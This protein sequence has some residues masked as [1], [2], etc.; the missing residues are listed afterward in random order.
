M[1][2][3]S[4]LFAPFYLSATLTAL[5]GCATQA[6]PEHAN[7]A[8]MDKKMA[9]T[10][11]KSEVETACVG[12]QLE[13]AKTV[14]AVFDS[15]GML[16]IGYV[17]DKYLYLQSSADRGQTFSPAVKVNQ[18]QEGIAARDESRPKIKFDA[19]DNLY[20]TWTSDI[21]N[22]KERHNGNVRFSRSTDGGKTFSVPVTVNDENPEVAGH[23]FD[24][25]AIGKNGEIFIA[26]LDARDKVA[27]K[28]S[29]TEHLGSSVY[30]AWSDDGGK[31]FQ[32]NKLAAAHSCECCRLQTDI[33]TDNKPVVVWRHVF[34]GGIRDHALLKFKDWN[35][36]GEVTRISYENW[37]IDACP[38]HGTGFSIAN[39]GTYHA[40]WFSNS[41]TQQ[42]LFYGYSSNQGKSFSK[43]VNFAKDGAGHPH[44]L[45]IGKQ[46]FIV[47][48][49]FDGKQTT[50]QLMKSND[51]GKTWGKA[52]AIAKTD[53][54]ADQ[55]FLVGDGKS[56]Y[57]SWK[58]A[59]QDYHLQRI[60]AK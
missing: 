18:E 22:A 56:A 46:V 28:K 43:P 26:W 33:D 24:S 49:H 12:S 48:Q 9:A 14:S 55:P 40:V 52:Q 20:L 41:P 16:W 5:A 57:L 19:Q 6:P 38:H 11:A 39:D 17:S 1:N 32:P 45:A 58:I 29:N 13:C 34:E 54:K 42:G 53:K 35:T 30:Y 23:R 60:T 47:W 15:K 21:P 25:L 7:H 4:R 37:K 51:G 10:A 27:A 50:A 44:V 36:P 8:E 2:K 3:S 59:P 31:H